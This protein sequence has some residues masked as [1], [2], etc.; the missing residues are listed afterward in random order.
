MKKMLVLAAALL[1]TAAASQA[2]VDV[3]IGIPLPPLPH[4][5]IGRPAP[6]PVVYAPPPRMCVPPAVVYA[7]PP[8]VVYAAPPVV[9]ARPGYY[10]H[11]HYHHRHYR[12]CG[13]HH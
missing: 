9:Y 3:H 1:G 11:G 10:G 8:P 6:P 5:V 12:G 4:I 7:P 13:H 2:G